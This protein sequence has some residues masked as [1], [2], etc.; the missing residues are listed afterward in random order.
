MKKRLII[1]IIS[2]SL[3]VTLGFSTVALGF[4][5]SD[6]SKQITELVEENSNLKQDA[7]ARAENIENSISE[8]PE[9]QETLDEE[10]KNDQSNST[11]DEEDL[12]KRMAYCFLV[13]QFE[14]NAD[15]YKSHVEDAKKYAT[16]EV[17]EQL[18]PDYG[19]SNMDDVAENIKFE[20][21]IKSKTV[22]LT[23]KN[24]EEYK[25]LAVV[26]SEYHTTSVTVPTPISNIYELTITKQK[27]GEWLVSGFIQLC[28]DETLYAE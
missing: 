25:A 22:Y 7:Q 4:N 13:A 12:A 16:E 8:A 10:N 11:E 17:F 15:T 27:T 3:N 19:E 23:E 20:S 1:S 5:L 14:Y 9:E 21:V 2:L 6:K 18:N 24:P 26:V 28:A